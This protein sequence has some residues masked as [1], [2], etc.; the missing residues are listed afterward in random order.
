M[1]KT[2]P[3]Q[4]VQHKIAGPYSPVLEVECDKIIVI[5]GQAAIDM[6][7]NVHGKSIVEQTEITLK[8]CLSQLGYAGCTFENVFK[9][10][11]FMA[12]LKMWDEFNTVYKKIMPEPRPVRT[13]VQVGLLPDLLVEIEMWAAK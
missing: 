8:N 1:K 10:N 3:E 12:D 7:G 5:S 13:A 9:V 2:V 4:A 6:E 11:V